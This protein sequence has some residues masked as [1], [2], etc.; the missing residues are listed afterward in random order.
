MSSQ[1]IEA[2]FEIVDWTET[3]YDEPAEGPKLVRITI[4]KR[5][6]GAIE[7]TGVAE[8]L[9]VRGAEG[10]G[11]LASERVV[12]SLNGR[13]GSF[14][15]QHGGLADGDHH[16]TFGTIVP[17]SGTGDLA[18]ITGHATEATQGV[19]TLEYDN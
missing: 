17:H 11:F 1:T 10:N 8:V 18:G 13:T 14:V 19:L 5:Y 15:I 3:P 7:G 2:K 4:S 6:S 12:G 9:A 16:S